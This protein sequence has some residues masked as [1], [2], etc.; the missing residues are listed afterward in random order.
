M[1]EKL[2]MR[3]GQQK[4][5]SLVAE[6]EIKDVNAVLLNNAE[7]AKAVLSVSE[8]AD[9]LGVSTD[10]IYTMVRENQIPYVRIRRRI[11][12][13]RESILEWLNM[14]NIHVCQVTS[15]EGES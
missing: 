1:E 4:I 9:Y 11:L 10:C 8:L 13:H 14:K 7:R 5:Q 6:D 3:V 15:K 12:F 2:L